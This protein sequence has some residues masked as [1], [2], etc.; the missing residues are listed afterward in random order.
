MNAVDYEAFLSAKAPTTEGYGFPCETSEVNPLLKPHQRDIVAWAVRGGRRG[1]FTAFG[2]GK[3]MIQL[4]VVRLV[5]KKLDDRPPLDCGRGL[6]VLPLGVRQE[7]FRDAEKLGTDVRFIRTTGEATG[8]DGIYITNFESVR[9]GKVDPG[10]FAVVSMDE[11]GI[12]RSFGSKTFSRFLYDTAKAP[13]RFVATAT[14]S[15]NDYIELLAYAQYLDIMDI[16]EAKTRFFKRNSEKADTLTLHPHKEKEFWLWV[17]SWALFVQAPSDLGHSDE[18]YELPPLEVRWHEIPSDHADAGVLRN[19]QQRLLANA[20]IGVQD[21]AREKRRSLPARVA[22]LKEIRAEEPNEHR[23]IWHDLEDERRAIEA[24][25]VRC[26]YGSQDIET[27]ELYTAEFADGCFAEIGAKPVM[28]GSGVNFQRHCSRAV[29]LGIGFKFN[30]FIQAIH[31]LQRFLQPNA[32]RIDLIYTE[33]EREV[34]ATLEKKW[35]KHEEL[36][37]NMTAIIREY[38]LSRSAMDEALGRTLGVQRHEDVG[39]TWKLVNNDSVVET[40]A[41]EADSVDLILTSIPFSTQYEYTPSYNDFGHTDDADHFFAQ[42]DFLSPELFRVLQPGRNLVIHVKDRVQPGAMTGYGFQVVQPFHADC[43]YHFRRHGFAYLGMKTIVTDVVRENNQTYRLG[44][45]EQCK[46]GSRMGCG[47]PE[48]LLVFRKPPTDSSDGYA[49]VPVVKTKQEYS[50]GRWQFDAHGFAR[51]NGNRLLTTYELAGMPM[52]RIFKRYREHSLTN[53][54]EH[55]RDVALAEWM[56]NPENKRRLPTDFTLFQLQSWHPDVWTDVTRMRTLNGAQR[57]KGREM[58]LCP[59]QFD[60]V[61]RV[62]MQMSMPGELVYDPFS[63]LGTVPLRAVK[64]GRRGLGVELNPNYHADAVYWLKRAEQEA[65]IPS[66]FDL[67]E[68]E[69]ALEMAAS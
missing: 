20:A 26:V 50:R 12:L 69:P 68:E 8:R 21:A 61:D 39:A 37:A 19:G 30:D 36:V 64:L 42:M 9:E 5:L 28:L 56:E 53:V 45:T 35:R 58:H 55:D 59:L 47:M 52:E 1:I 51:S 66:L 60:I 25:G 63:G 16:G 46:D 11:A 62:V 13:Y 43:I 48:Y 31:R 10:A 2:L 44:W 67:L 32:V 38:G 17:A 22:K 18:G 49:D 54:Y 57:A 29:F 24:L 41:M 14:P 27:N 6:I 4:E 15:P 33:A 65:A 34:R 23:I 40:A 7:F 3:T